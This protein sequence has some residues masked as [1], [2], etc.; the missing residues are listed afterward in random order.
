MAMKA[1]ILYF[2]VPTPTTTCASQPIKA[3][4]SPSWKCNQ[5]NAFVSS[6]D[7]TDSEKR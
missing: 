5:I 2:E 3:L 7:K 1:I 6:Q 4:N